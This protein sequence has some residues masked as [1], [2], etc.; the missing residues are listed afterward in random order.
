MVEVTAETKERVIASF[1]NA[2]DRHDA[3][4]MM[5]HMSDD[6]MFETAG[7]PEVFGNRYLGRED[8]RSGFASLWDG[9]PDARWVVSSIVMCGDRA[10]SEWTVSAT[11]PDGGRFEANGVD[12]FT[13]DADMIA[14][15]ISYRKYR[16]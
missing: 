16:A 9:L 5:S 7:G 13:F 6:C 1:L 8:V 11:R 15:V 14:V 4:S 10:F 12:L 3:D 2:L